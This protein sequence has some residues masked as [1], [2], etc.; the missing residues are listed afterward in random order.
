M[1]NEIWKDITGFEGL[2]KFSNLYRVK[3]VI[4]NKIIK[5]YIDSCGY[6]SVNLCKKDTRKPVRMHRL[7][8]EYFVGL[9]P[10]KMECRHLNGI[11]TNY[12]IKNLIWG[13]RSENCQDTIKHG[14]K[15]RPIWINNR[16]SKNGKSK[17]INKEIMEILKL[18]DEKILTQKEI[19]Y[20]YNVSPSTIC[21]IKK[22]RTWKE[23]K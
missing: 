9:C 20:Y 10:Q 11:R 13:T 16:G 19:A 12:M 3:N 5:I 21:D 15:P 1:Q 22:K 14:N 17:L 2:Y 4:S 23:I 18:I 7:V 6:P 8:L